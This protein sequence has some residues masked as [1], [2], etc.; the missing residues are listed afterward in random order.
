MNNGTWLN[1]S[2]GL[3]LFGQGGID[4]LEESPHHEN[5]KSEMRTALYKGQTKITI[6]KESLETIKILLIGV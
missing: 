1:L 2:D 4:R 5:G 3:Y 6:V